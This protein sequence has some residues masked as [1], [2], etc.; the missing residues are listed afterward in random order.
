[1]NNIDEMKI[2]ITSGI[3]LLK[4][5]SITILELRGKSLILFAMLPTKLLEKYAC[6]CLFTYSKAAILILASNLGYMAAEAKPCN[7]IKNSKNIQKA[8]AEKNKCPSWLKIKLLSSAYPLSASII[9][10]VIYGQIELDKEVARHA[11]KKTRKLAF[12]L[13]MKCIKYPSLLLGMLDIGHNNSKGG[14]Q[15]NYY[16]LKFLVIKI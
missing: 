13:F 3:K 16:T 9:W 8:K 12:C 15:R 6:E 14:Y 11:M 2:A 7:L 10:P 4:I 5:K 1:M